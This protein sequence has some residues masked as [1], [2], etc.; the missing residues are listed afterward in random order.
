MDKK[1]KKQLYLLLIGLLPLFIYAQISDKLTISKQ[2]IK[3]EKVNGYDKISWKS[4]YR[5]QE[6]GSPELPV[7]R[8]SYVLPIDAQV[9]S[10]SFAVQTKQK[11]EQNFNIIPVQQPVLADNPNAP[12]FTPSNKA[13]YQSTSSYPKK[14]YEVESD[15]FYMGYH[16]V[17]LRIYPFEYVPSTQILYY[18]SQLEFAINYVSSNNTNEISPQ[19][20]NLHRAEQCKTLVQ[21]MVRNPDDVEKFGSNVQ[22]IRN[23]KNIIQNLKSTTKSSAPQKTKSLS[24]LDE[25]VPDYIIIT[26][27]ALKPTFQTLADWKTKKGVFAIIKTTEEISTNYQGTDIQEKIRNF[28]IESWGKWGHGLFFLLG[29]G[30]NIVPARMIAGDVYYG[31]SKTFGNEKLHYPADMYY[32]TYI[33]SWNNNHNNEFNEQIYSSGGVYDQNFYLNVDNADFTLSGIFLG[34]IPV[35]NES[36]AS[37]MVNKI[38]TYEKANTTNNL[39][40]L[41]NHLY[42]DYFYG[43]YVSNFTTSTT[44]NIIK[45][46]MVSG[47]SGNEI[48]FNHNNFLNALNN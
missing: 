42:A 35:D 9:T 45:K 39:S 31:D 29:G 8:V 24:V 43:I 37:I 15:H 47:A 12:A 14:L 6:V 30:N 23:G 44:S 1:M 40:Y 2:D 21:S 27:N 4:D 41:Q 48:E 32:C 17:T 7:Y 20:Q 11:H 26:N 16:L 5:T 13:V 38:I 46:Y 22:T 10:V 19:T 28:I 33:N 18:Y 36:D 3:T 25:Q 34:R